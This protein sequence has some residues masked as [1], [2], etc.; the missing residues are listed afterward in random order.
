MQ[1][2]E[3]LQQGGHL[4]RTG[5]VT[6]TYRPGEIWEPGDIRQLVKHYRQWGKRRRVKIGI[7]WVA[8][9]HGGYGENHGQ[10]HYHLVLFLPRGLTPPLPDKQGWWRKGMSNCKWARS[11]VGY[12]AKYASKGMS[13]PVM[14]SGARLWGISG[15]TATVRLRLAY[16]LA[17][18]W[19][20]AFCQPDEVVKKIA[21][22]W[23]R[24]CTTGWEYRS[25]WEFE[26]GKDGPALKW[27]G[28]TE[29]DVAYVP[30]A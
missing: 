19:L 10:V 18:T 20:R 3:E 11:P 2:Q 5:F 14:P 16:A 6:V 25:P 13:D 17:P 23:W 28:W 29:W 1:M 21:H 12:L 15:L 9:T 27:R 4:Y 24:N 7:V 22:G 30:A 26:W 8:E